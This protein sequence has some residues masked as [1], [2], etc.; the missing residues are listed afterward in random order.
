M[1]ERCVSL[2]HGVFPIVATLNRLTARVR[3]TESAAHEGLLL[4]SDGIA[5]RA[6]VHPAPRPGTGS[7]RPGTLLDA[8]GTIACGTS[9]LQLLQVQRAGKG[10]MAADEFMR[11]ARLMPGTVLG[12]KA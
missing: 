8:N 10:A 6:L 3:V 1:H 2:P 5:P 7:G 4:A 9:A 12:Q 11:G